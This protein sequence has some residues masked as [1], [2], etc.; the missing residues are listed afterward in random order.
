MEIADA[1]GAGLRSVPAGSV[2]I[3]PGPAGE[4][5]SLVRGSLAVGGRAA[6][7]EEVVLGHL[8]AARTPRPAIVTD[9]AGGMTLTWARLTF[10]LARFEVFAFGA[11]ILALDRR[12]DPGGG[13]DRLAA[14]GGKLL[15]VDPRR[16]AAARLRA[17]A[18]RLVFGPAGRRGPRRRVADLRLV[19]GR[20]LPRRAD[21]RPRAR[22]RDDPPRL[23]ADAVADALVRRP[24]GA[25]PR[26]ARGRHVPGGGGRRSVRRRGH[27]VGGPVQLVHRVRVPRPAHREPRGLHLRG[28]GRRRGDR[29]ARPARRSSSRRSSRRSGSPV[30]RPS[31]SGSCEPR[32]SRSRWT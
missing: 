20:H 10:R 12:L 6:T 32:P 19:R 11:V 7:L 27:P 28:G 23:V 9:G 15:R 2:G 3:F 16:H 26:R 30:A 24:H 21:R 17:G 14:T 18:H 29:G 8:A 13:M 22:A 25:D 5:L 4:R 1:A 31:T